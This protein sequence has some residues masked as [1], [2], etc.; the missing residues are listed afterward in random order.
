MARSTTAKFHAVHLFHFILFYFTC[1]AGF[2]T[3]DNEMNEVS[4]LL[5]AC[6]SQQKDND[7]GLF[8]DMG[9]TR[10]FH[11]GGRQRAGHGGTQ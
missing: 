9:G 5:S 8:S 11:M 7:E 3:W 2:K 10:D 6:G 1:T 4:E